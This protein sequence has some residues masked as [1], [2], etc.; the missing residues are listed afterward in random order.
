[1]IN[2]L[3]MNPTVSIV[4]PTR[5]GSR[6][7]NDAI[8]SCVEQTHQ[9]WELIIVDD[10]SNDA[11]PD[12]IQQW[13][14][15]DTRIRSLRNE[16]NRKLPAS[17]NRGFAEARGAFLTWTSD[18]NLYRPPALATMLEF[19]KSHPQVGMVYADYTLI[20]EDGNVLRVQPVGN[21]TGLVY[22][23]CINCCFLYRREV[24]R[25]IG[26]YEERFVLVEDLDYWLRVAKRFQL[27]PLH[28]D[29]YL[30]REHRHSLTATREFD[31]RKARERVLYCH[32][33]SARLFDARA[34]ANGLMSLCRTAQ[35][36]SRKKDARRF[37]YKALRVSP[38]TALSSLMI[39]IISVLLGEKLS[40]PARGL[41]RKLRS[42]GGGANGKQ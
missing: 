27:A 2:G 24:M 9:D 5:N 41:Y 6:Y 22:S 37:F 13:K 20:D 21:P 25:E 17:L 15:R 35:H 16:R 39:F 38:W 4:L 40:S 23:N 30:Y 8:Q 33:C 14:G 1:M 34:R 31:V 3:S 10:A 36:G 19:L 29:L 32:L 42:A 12:I 28:Q 26:D 18:D 7:L 11:T